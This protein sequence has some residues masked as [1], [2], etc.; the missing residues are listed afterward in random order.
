MPI[1]VAL[2]NGVS[3]PVPIE[4][5]AGALKFIARMYTPHGAPTAGKFSSAVTLNV[6]YN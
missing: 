4:N 2:A 1:H 3:Y 6:T 5:G